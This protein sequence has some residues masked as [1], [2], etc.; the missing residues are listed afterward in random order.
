MTDQKPV[1][2]VYTKE[3]LEVWKDSAT[4][5]ELLEFV[6]S[7]QNAVVGKANDDP[8]FVS[9]TV[10][11][12]LSLLDSINSIIDKHPVEHEKDVSRFGK[13]EF[14][15]FY[16]EVSELATNLVK[17]V[18][19]H[20]NIDVSTYL[21]ESWGDSKRID[22]GSGHELNFMCFL[23]CLYKL[24]L[25]N[26]QDFPA[27]ILRVFTKYMSIMRRLQKIYWLEP[28]GSHGVW[29][30]DDYHFLPFLFGAAQLTHH[31]HM[32]PKSIHNEELVEMY[33]D[34]YIYLEC[35]DF[36]N[37][38]KTSSND[39]KLSLRWHSPM[40]DDISS[41]KSWEKIKD[42]MV[43]MYTAEVLGKLPIIQHFLFGSILK[44][45]AGIPEH[46][47]EHEHEEGD[48]C[49]HVHDV[50]NTWGDCCGIKIPSAVAAS[51][52]LKMERKGIPF[53]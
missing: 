8:C 11:H 1:R 47:E 37:K 46:N 9:T 45:P 35:I 41:A 51:E 3:D 17:G 43:K 16:T 48:G 23:L 40:L 7:L 4:Y 10:D 24:E 34:K 20:E 21:L 53:D 25:I 38:I 12:I 13:I 32:R 6:C 28:A 33:K 29:G 42:G 30:L 49:G 27:I 19:G 15:D 50:A 52:Q 36:I 44:C 22:Y 14:R 26:E 31:P 39:Q 18:V 5:N 2:R